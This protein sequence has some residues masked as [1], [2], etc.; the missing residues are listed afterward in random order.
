MLQAAEAGVSAAS[1]EIHNVHV[2]M[3]HKGSQVLLLEDINLDPLVMVADN[4]TNFKEQLQ[5]QQDQM[6][7]N[8]SSTNFPK[9]EGKREAETQQA[10]KGERA[11]QQQ[12]GKQDATGQALKR[13]EHLRAHTAHFREAERKPNTLQSLGKK[14]SRKT[15]Y[16]GG[17]HCC[18]RK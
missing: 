17:P 4:Y 1:Y 6:M 13:M 3:S 15:E 2:R 8:T 11:E 5:Q 14:V 18:A 7:R 10:T 16:G 12:I 9:F